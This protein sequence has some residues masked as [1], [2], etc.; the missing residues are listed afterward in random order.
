M[1]KNYCGVTTAREIWTD[2]AIECYKRCCV[3]RDCFYFVFFDNGCQQK[4]QM[5]ASVLELVKTFGRPR[6]V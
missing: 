6:E 5:K 2:T 3:C 1:I 4:Y